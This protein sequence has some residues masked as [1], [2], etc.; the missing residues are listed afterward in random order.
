MGVSEEWRNVKITGQPAIRH[1]LVSRCLYPT[2]HSCSS[3]HV[4]HRGTPYGGIQSPT[5]PPPR[6]LRSREDFST[7]PYVEIVVVN[8]GTGRSGNLPTPTEHARRAQMSAGMQ[9]GLSCAI[10]EWKR[11]QTWFVGAP[12]STQWRGDRSGSISQPVG[13]SWYR[14]RDHRSRCVESESSAH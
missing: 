10:Q 14:M 11:G 12:R 4:E 7:M 9:G 3:G 8:G 6:E 2:W 5:C 1:S 13:L